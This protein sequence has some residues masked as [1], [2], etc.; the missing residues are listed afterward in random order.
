[1]GTLV[2]FKLGAFTSGA[3]LNEG[4]YQLTDHSI[5]LWDYDGK[6]ATNVLALRVTAQPG[7]VQGK[8]FT[9]EGEPIHQ[10]YSIGDAG[11]FGPDDT[12]KKIVAIGTR[13]SLGKGSNFYIYM[14]NLINAGFP[15]DRFDN[16]V[17]VFDNMVVHI[18]PIPAPKRNLPQSNLVAGNPEQQQ[19]DRTI[20]VVSLI[21][22]MPWEA[23]G[24]APAKAAGKTP[25]KTPAKAAAPAPAEVESS[26][27]LTEDLGV[28]IGGILNG[29]ATMA[30]TVLRV[31][32]FKTL[33]ADKVDQT[34]RDAMMKVFSNDD[35]LGAVLAGV[36]EGYYIEGTDVKK[37]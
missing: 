34:T 8:N 27:D 19:R 2:S 36:G 13:A 12:G 21:H 37:I 30:R 28:R 10:H 11:A 35:E 1:M 26:G 20:P 22:R 17:S 16:D 9:P 4:D 23:A 32:L 6:M 24:G 7:R 5:V 15:E 29:A 33:N 25:A 18:T 31:N 3:G 14:E